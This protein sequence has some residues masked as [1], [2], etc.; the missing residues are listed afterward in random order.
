MTW[1][2]HRIWPAV[3]I[4]ALLAASP[5]YAQNAYGP[6]ASDTEIKLGQSTPLSGPASAFGAGAGRAVVGYFEMLNAQGGINGRKISFTQLDNAYSAPK[7]VEQSRKLIEDVGVLA[8]VGTIGT[9]PNVAIQKYL[10][11]KQVPQL[12]ITA[13]G[14]RFNDPKAFPWTVP[15]YPDFETEGRVVAKYIA[16]AKPDAKIGVL[17]QNDDYGKDYLK[18]LRAGLGEK[19]AQIVTAVSYELADPTIDSQ[20]VQLKAAGIDTLIEQ[21]SSKAAAQSIRKVYELKWRPL[22]VI[23]GSTASVETILKPAGLEASKGLV[24]TQFL[25]QP[26]DP[27]WVDDE[28]VKAYKSFLKKY[29]PSAN[30]DDYSVLVAYMNVHAVTLALKK[31]GDQ[32]TRDN[33]IRQATSLHGERLPMMLP[34]IS[35]SMHPD[36]YTPFKTLRIAIFDGESWTLAGDPLS[37]E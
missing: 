33:L 2:I 35:I 26:G 5:A 15:L 22:H 20:I 23:G 11:S 17:Y 21:S 7:A 10:N 4:S 3:A 8:E 24:T 13:G 28:E 36:D 14:R 16:R 1:T 27:A 19:A 37:A 12:F 6:G 9:A 31:C 34:G 29:A 18:G 25:K 30:P 32:L